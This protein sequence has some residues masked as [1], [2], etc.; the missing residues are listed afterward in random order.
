MGGIEE[1]NKA[2]SW[3]HLKNGKSRQDEDT[4]IAFQIESRAIGKS[5]CTRNEISSLGRKNRHPIAP[6]SPNLLII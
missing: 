5:M 4:E 3:K 1:L 6:N 2:A